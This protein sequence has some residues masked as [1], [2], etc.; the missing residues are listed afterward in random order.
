MNRE[1][2][3]WWRLVKNMQQ[4]ELVI[5][6]DLPDLDVIDWSSWF[7]QRLHVQYASCV[8]M[9]VSVFVFTFSCGLSVLDWFGLL[10]LCG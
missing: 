10:P 2:L 5:W 9:Y 8:Y 1:Y 6:I 3:L 4:K 7:Y